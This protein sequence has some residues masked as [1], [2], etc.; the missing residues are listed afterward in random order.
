M[1]F[2]G[3]HRSCHELGVIYIHNLERRFVYEDIDERTR[4]LNNSKPSYRITMEIRAYQ[5]I[6][7]LQGQNH[8]TFSARA[9]S[10]SEYAQDQ[11]HC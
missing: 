5:I 7:L 3:H 6:I 8:S 2:R 4:L 11:Y 9:S 1:D 10:S